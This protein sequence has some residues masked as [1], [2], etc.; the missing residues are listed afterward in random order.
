MLPQNSNA[1]AYVQQLAHALEL[2]LSQIP[3]TELAEARSA[4]GFHRSIWE[5]AEMVALIHPYHRDQLEH[6]AAATHA[7]STL[8]V[9]LRGKLTLR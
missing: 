5:L 6:I 8:K 1:L 9:G 3:V 7:A 2:R 4:P